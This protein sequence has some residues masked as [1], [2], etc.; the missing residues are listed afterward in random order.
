MEAIQRWRASSEGVFTLSDL[1]VALGDRT[2]AALYQ[3][4]NGPIEAGSNQGEAGNLRDSGGVPGDAISNRIRAVCL[5]LDRHDTR[6]RRSDWIHSRPAESR[7]SRGA[8]AHLPLQAGTIEHLS[9]QSNAIIR[10]RTRRRNS[11][12]DA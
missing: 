8:S 4:L 5:Y 6:P 3:R 9:N 11:L 7:R 10:I 12:C 1:R 2:E